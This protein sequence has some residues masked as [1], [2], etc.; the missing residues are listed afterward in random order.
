MPSAIVLS[1]CITTVNYFINKHRRNNVKVKY[2][3]IVTIPILKSYNILRFI[4]TNSIATDF[5][6]PTK[7]FLLTWSNDFQWLCN[8]LGYYEFRP[9]G[10]I[11]LF[12][13]KAF[14]EA[15]SLAEGVCDNMLF[16]YAGY[17]SKRLIKVR[18]FTR[19]DINLLLYYIHF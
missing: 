1:V 9:N 14:C 3:I 15:N 12:A 4:G 17:D 10:K 16:L 18:V 6:V 7:H 11:L 2:I 5:W 13:G 8:S 19:S